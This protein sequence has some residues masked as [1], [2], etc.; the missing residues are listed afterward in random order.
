MEVKQS[1]SGAVSIVFHTPT[2]PQWLKPNFIVSGLVKGLV[3]FFQ[4]VDRLLSHKAP[5]IISAG[6][7][8][9]IGLS[10]TVAGQPTMILATPSSQVMNSLAAVTARELRLPEHKVAGPILNNE[11]VVRLGEAGVSV[12]T[13]STNDPIASD[14]RQV[15]L[16][17]SIQVVGSN[18]GVYLYQVVETREIPH[19]EFNTLLE[20]SQP[21]LLIST[22][23]G[24]LQT[25]DW[26]LVARPTE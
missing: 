3:S 13:I 9:G 20:Q 26:V 14:I 21:T 8:L 7:G 25:A 17:E 5:L 6:L 18:N 15:G 22:P 10:L 1:K 11:Q 2:I 24:L 19:H 16:G 4:A 12:I 23:V